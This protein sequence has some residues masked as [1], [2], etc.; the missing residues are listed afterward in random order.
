[1]KEGDSL[2]YN[3]NGNKE[4][5]CDIAS[6]ESWNP[7]WYDR[8]TRRSRIYIVGLVAADPETS[9]KNLR[10]G[11]SVSVGKKYFNTRQRWNESSSSPA[12]KNAW[13]K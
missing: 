5:T 7:P 1:M 6:E 9:N 13:R 11:C 12:V 10:I 2:I 4:F 3:Q 8:T